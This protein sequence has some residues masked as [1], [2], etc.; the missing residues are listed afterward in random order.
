MFP[1]ERSLVEKLKDAPFALIGVN[2][3]GKNTAALKKKEFVEEKI[4]W[5]NFYD[6]STSGPIAKS[7]NV[8]GWPTLVLLDAEGRISQ[9]WLGGPDPDVMES[10]IEKLLAEAKKKDSKPAGTH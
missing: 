3:D 1:H 2:S 5:R 9:R 4:T 7:W 8:H 10:A 6:E